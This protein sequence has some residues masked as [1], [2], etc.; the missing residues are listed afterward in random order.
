[1]KNKIMSFLLALSICQVMVVPAFAVTP[2]DE[3]SPSSDILHYNTVKILEDLDK[4]LT[5]VIKEY[6]DTATGYEADGELLSIESGLSATAKLDIGK[7]ITGIVT[8]GA[9][10]GSG[11]FELSITGTTKVTR[12]FRLDFPS[13]DVVAMVAAIERYDEYLVEQFYVTDYGATKKEVSQG[14]AIIQE[15]TL[16]YFD[17]IYV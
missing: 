17:V 2:S 16:V 12:N 3:I 7:I 6:D 13:D 15:P 1:M 11:L 5:K 9:V 14:T 4:G 10:S 8:K